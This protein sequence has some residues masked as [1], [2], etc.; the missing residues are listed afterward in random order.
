MTPMAFA[1]PSLKVDVSP[2]PEYSQLWAYDT[3]L[4]NVSLVDFN[5]SNVNLTDYSQDPFGLEYYMKFTW[6]VIGGY[7]FGNASTGYASTPKS[8][9]YQEKTNLNNSSPIFNFTIEKDSYEYGALPTENV[10]MDFNFNIYLI[11]DDDST[12]PR[13]ASKSQTYELMDESKVAF[14][15]G[16][17][18]EMNIELKAVLDSKGLDDFNRER[19]S[20]ILADMNSSLNQG[21]YIEAQNIWEDYNEDDRT[22]MII[23]LIRASD[24]QTEKLESLESIEENLTRVENELDLLE[25]EYEQLQRT[26]STL[27]N[28]YQKINIRLESLEKNLST[29]ITGVFLA[30]IVFFFIGRYSIEREGKNA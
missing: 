17:Y 25:E 27:A 15:E 19:Y 30:S 6:R 12:G 14:F 5:A 1:E 18:Y 2:T 9:Y 13:I 4:F 3:Y 11:M 23:G 8:V 24:M 26:Y 7:H 20:T 16:K 10:R 22:D 29:A 28:T 21:N